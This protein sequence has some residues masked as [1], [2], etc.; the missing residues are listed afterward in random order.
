[1]INIQ[2]VIVPTKGT[3]NKVD[4]FIQPFPLSPTEGIQVM[5]YLTNDQKEH[6]L[7]GMVKVPQSVYDEW[8][9]DDSHIVNYCLKELNLQAV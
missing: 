3:A 8:G 7:R 2:E 6:I 9:S 1:M 5:F 4:F